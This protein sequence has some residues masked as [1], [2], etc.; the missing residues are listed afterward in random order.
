[1]QSITTLWKGVGSTLMVKGVAVA[2]EAAIHE[3]TPLPRFPAEKNTISVSHVWLLLSCRL[4]FLPGSPLFRPMWF[5]L[6]EYPTRFI[7]FEKFVVWVHH[8][9]TVRWRLWLYPRLHWVAYN[10]PLG[11]SAGFR[12]GEENQ[13][14]RGKEK[15]R[16]SPNLET[17]PLIDALWLL[18][19]A[20]A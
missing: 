5:T 13:G 15:G 3:F 4:W 20:R 12:G 17:N 10:T 18:L 14:R 11:L 7:Q 16:I 6:F 2:S 1:M 9:A 19:A 8:S